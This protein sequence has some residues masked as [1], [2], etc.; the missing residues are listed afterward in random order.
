MALFLGRLRWQSYGIPSKVLEGPV[1]GVM[2]WSTIL[3]SDLQFRKAFSS[4]DDNALGKIN[5]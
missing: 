2:D 3:F 4:I 5:C 1:G